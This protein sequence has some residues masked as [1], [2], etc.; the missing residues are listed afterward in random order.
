MSSSS[1]SFTKPSPSL[2]AGTGED[3]WSMDDYISSQERIPSRVEQPLYRLG[4]LSPHSKEEHL[5]PG[6]KIDL[7]L[8][9]ARTLCTRRR[10]VSNRVLIMGNF[11]KGSLR[12]CMLWDSSHCSSMCHFLL[13]LLGSISIVSKGL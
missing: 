11:L 12:F 10:Q 1:Q 7:P 8:W 9:L 6:A 5:L 4:F 3:Y 13:L 2:P